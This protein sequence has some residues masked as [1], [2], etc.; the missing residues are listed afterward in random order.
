MKIFV[1]KKMINLALIGALASFSGCATLDG[2]KEFGASLIAD[3]VKPVDSGTAV[4][5]IGG[6]PMIMNDMRVG[7]VGMHDEWAEN[8]SCRFK[9]DAFGYGQQKAEI[10]GFDYGKKKVRKFYDISENKL[11][12]MA[13]VDRHLY[14]KRG[15]IIPH[16]NMRQGFVECK[17]EGEGLFNANP[18]VE[19]WK[20]AVA[21]EWMKTE[22]VKNPFDKP[23]IE[24]GKN[25]LIV[26]IG[27]PKVALQYG[28]NTSEELAYL[29]SYVVPMDYTMYLSFH[30]GAFNGY[31]GISE[32][33]GRTN[34]NL[35]EYKY[36]LK[37]YDALK[38]EMILRKMIVNEFTTQ[39]QK[40]IVE[41]RAKE[42]ADKKRE[43][44]EREAGK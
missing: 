19:I 7:G 26:E 41:S 3:P 21:S 17:A 2:A 18:D 32:T 15:Q 27:D 28:Y 11:E 38:R 31:G 16:K 9:S 5:M 24:T 1:N 44:E 40:K 10:R 12:K 25:V 29:R 30:K 33:E 42:L 39:Y 22:I 6:K 37:R 35:S 4:K 14:N 23:F 20:H 43:R 36:I 34:P 13:T 8:V